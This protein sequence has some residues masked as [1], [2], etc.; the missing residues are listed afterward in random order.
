MAVIRGTSVRKDT[1]SLFDPEVRIALAIV[2]TISVVYVSVAVAR[3]EYL[4]AEHAIASLVVV[5][6]VVLA[7]ARLLHLRRRGGADH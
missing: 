5:V 3:H 6:G 1:R 2:W 4:G 7:V